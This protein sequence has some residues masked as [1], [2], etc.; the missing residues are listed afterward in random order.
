MLRR[1]AYG[2]NHNGAPPHK[3]KLCATQGYHGRQ[4]MPINVGIEY[5][6]K[7]IWGMRVVSLLALRHWSLELKYQKV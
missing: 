4:W 5:A 1:V 3:S 6:V 2:A 7:K